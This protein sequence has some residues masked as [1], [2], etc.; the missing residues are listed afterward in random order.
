MP[1]KERAL[2]AVIN[3]LSQLSPRLASRVALELFTRPRRPPT[4][5]QTVEWLRSATELHLS[6]EGLQLRG[7]RWAA[8]DAPPDA[9]PNV[10][11]VHGWESHAGR[12][13]SLADGLLAAG[14]SVYA[15]DGPASGASTGRRT[16][17]IRYTGALVQFERS[18]GPFDAL[19]GHS[20]G[21]GVAAQ[22]L[23]RTPLPR[24]AKAAVV[25]AS[26]DEP[27][28]VFDRYFDLLGMSQRTR[29]RFDQRALRM[30]PEA[31]GLENYSTTAAL[32]ALGKEVRGLVVHALDDE[33]S[34]FAE[35][36]AI[37]ASWAGSELWE[38]P[39]GGH[40][41]REPALQERIAA[42]LRGAIS[43]ARALNTNT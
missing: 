12:W 37:H 25:M 29:Q 34:P 2:G 19:V 10:L 42:W 17:L 4:R 7:Y 15:L 33:V 41:L 8:P 24:R 32:R 30:V 20:L 9:H 38:L 40:R 23:A 3:A 35:G 11:L 36:K 14:I 31:G 21:G 16:N 26:F 22:L 43:P 18:F 28:H 1:S 27:E 13:R 6:Y 5:P 39:H